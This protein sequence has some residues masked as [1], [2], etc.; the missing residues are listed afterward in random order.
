MSLRLVVVGWSKRFG[1]EPPAVLAS[2]PYE[3]A[4][5]SVEFGGHTNLGAR[6]MHFET[7]IF[8]ING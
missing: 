5:T 7:P 6:N 3:G 4:Y 8:M 1:H 2:S